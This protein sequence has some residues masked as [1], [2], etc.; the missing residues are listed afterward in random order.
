M[1]ERTTIVK[2]AELTVEEWGGEAATVLKTT[3]GSCVGVFLLDPRRRVAGLAHIMLPASIPRDPVVG[4]YADTA[5]P[6]L[7][8]KLEERGCSRRDMQASL[9]GGARMFDTGNSKGLSAIGDMNVSA[10]KKILES[11]CIPVVFE[12]TG[13]AQ[14]RTVRYDSREKEPSVHLLMQ[15]SRGAQNG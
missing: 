4:K 2:M 6:T 14:G 11:F 10:S 1:T 9:V 15:P 8:R 7:V 3:L 13:G 12:R 5:I